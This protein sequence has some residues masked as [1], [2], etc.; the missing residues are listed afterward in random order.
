MRHVIVV[1]VCSCFSL[2][3]NSRMCCLFMVWLCVVQKTTHKQC[4]VD[5][6]C[7]VC[8]FVYCLFT[9]YVQL[10]GD[11]MVCQNYSIPGV[12]GN[13]SMLCVSECPNGYYSSG[14]T[15]MKCNDSCRGEECTGPSPMLG[16][17]GC[18]ACPLVKES[19]GQY[20][21]SST[22]EHTAIE[23]VLN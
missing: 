3:L 22:I 21:A 18:V 16:V 13:Q 17:G 10:S 2:H 15:C 7:H 19:N 6:I 8:C 12:E 1:V 5:N 9:F 23:M 20:E 11:C 14:S 4:Y